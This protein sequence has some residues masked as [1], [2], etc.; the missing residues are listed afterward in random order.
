M[1]IIFFLTY[2]LSIPYA[3]A[4]GAQEHLRDIRHKHNLPSI[5][6]ASIINDETT[7]Y[8]SGYRK[9]D[10]SIKITAED[11]FHLGSCTKAMTATLVA[12]FVEKKR[13]KWSDKILK[14][15]PHLKADLHEE[16]KEVTL[17]DLGRHTS[18]ITDEMLDLFNGELWSYLRTPGLNLQEA[19]TYA[20][21]KV[22]SL[23]PKAKPQKQFLYSNWNYVLLGAILEKVSG[24][25]WENLITREIFQPLGMSSCG[26]AHPADPSLTEPDQP[27]PHYIEQNLTKAITPAL[28]SDNPQTIAPAG[29]VH[30]S[31]IDWGKFLKLH[32]DGYNKKNTVILKNSSFEILH[33]ATDGFNYTPGGWGRYQRSWADNFVLTHSGSNLVNYAVVWMAPNRNAAFFGVTNTGPIPIAE[34]AVDEAISHLVSDFDQ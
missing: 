11:K 23:P 24:S 22:L 3:L 31:L 27:W 25:S 9:A 20:L 5:A 6:V 29:T 13:L 4:S 30:C 16:L 7:I 21:E 34:K 10:Q 15:I 26:F 18:G 32:L 28:N 12:I 8:V 19:R 33:K 2:C 14:H 1:R 17:Q